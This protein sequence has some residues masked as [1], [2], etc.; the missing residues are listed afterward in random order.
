[1][2]FRTF[3]LVAIALLAAAT[4]ASAQPVSIVSIV[5]DST[6][7]GEA[8]FTLYVQG[9]GFLPGVTVA[10]NG[11]ALATSFVNAD[12][13]TAVVPA[14]MIASVGPVSIT[15]ANSG[16][17]PSNALQ[18]MI[19]ATSATPVLVAASLYVGTGSGYTPFS[20]VWAG[21]TNLEPNAVLYWNGT[22]IP[23][24]FGINELY[25]NPV[26]ISLAETSGQVSITALNPGNNTPSNPVGF[27]IPSL[28]TLDSLNPSLVASGSS[29]FTIA[30]NGT[31]FTPGDQIFL[32]TSNGSWFASNPIFTGS[33]QIQG[34]VP[35]GAVAVPGS[36][37]VSVLQ[38]VLNNVPDC[39]AF[40]PSGLCIEGFGS[41]NA[42]PL[43]I[44]TAP[45]GGCIYALNPPGQAWT[46]AGGNG[47]IAITATP[48]CAWGVTNL[49]GWVQ[50]T[51]AGAGIGN[52]TVTYQVA[53]NT[54]GD[55]ATTLSIAGLPFAIEQ[56]SSTLPGT[57]TTGSMAQI[58]AGGSWITFITLVNTGDS[59]AEARLNFLDDNGN[60]EPVILS[61][62]PSN[63][64]Q[65]LASTLDRVLNPGAGLVV[66]ITSYTNQSTQA[67]WTQL[68]TNGGINGYAVVQQTIGST[69]Q[70][71][72]VPV[73]TT[74]AGKYMLWF[75]NTGG[76]ATGV[77]LQNSTGQ[78]ANIGVIL[79]DD[80]GATT[81]Q[82][83]I[84]LPAYG[85]SSFNLATNYPSTSQSL[86]TIEFDAP[87]NGQ[88]SVVGFRF[89]PT[90]AFSTVPPVVVGAP[91]PVALTKIGAMSQLAAEGSWKTIFTLLNPGSAQAQAQLN[92]FG[93]GGDPLSLLLDF[94]QSPGSPQQVST[95]NSALN[96]NAGL[97]IET[98]GP[99]A[100]PTEVGWAQLLGT[101]FLTGYAVFQQT[102][103]NTVQEASVAVDPGS[104]SDYMVW[105]DNTNG[106]ATGIALAN[107]STSP[108]NVGV[109]I[110]DD[111]GAVILQDSISLPAQGHT[112]FA[113]SSRWATTGS[114]RGTVEFDGPGSGAISVLGLRFNPTG[115]FSSVPAMA[116]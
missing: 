13:L 27:T 12:A 18:F 9:S 70:E 32:V 34:S 57:T 74:N 96:G 101:G 102:I 28:P 50:L 11:S 4:G 16:H 71:A 58:A 5:P 65:E 113:V 93:D 100:Q 109:V 22:P 54:G 86:G 23:T 24:T 67:D 17:S 62:P 55:L 105:F 66:E 87:A 44:G 51:N 49:P 36:A 39:G 97:E 79:R 99:D 30:V 77:A 38:S 80:T 64:G 7:A 8:T 112:S 115:A 10:W 114:E 108:I 41:V 61:F 68:I 14:A 35:A 78:A 83:V 98:A 6:V 56:A 29:G 59:P 82:N 3:T 33:T 31:G 95:L 92:F 1:M 111:T 20:E 25:G 110:R 69:V 47:T 37:T 53:P 72:A 43:T 90:G 76:F 46:S 52:G 60:P 103:N 63:T 26:P 88:I 107:T 116:R 19:L 84:A 40:G 91:D 42:L 81:S 73:D 48:G 85:H 45:Q 104:A 75:D 21:G 15:A 89:N 106:Y 94:P 2:G